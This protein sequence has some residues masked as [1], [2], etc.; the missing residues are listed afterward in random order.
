MAVEEKKMTK[1]FQNEMQDSG[2]DSE[3]DDFEKRRD[4]NQDRGK[5]E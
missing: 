1:V 3:E 5:R 2:G 4:K